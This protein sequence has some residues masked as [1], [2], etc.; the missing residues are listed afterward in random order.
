MIKKKFILT[1]LSSYSGFPESSQYQAQL[2]SST[3]KCVL[4]MAVLIDVM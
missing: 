1:R 4:E 2:A 3:S